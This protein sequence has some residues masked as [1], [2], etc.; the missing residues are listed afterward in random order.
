MIVVWLGLVMDFSLTKFSGTVN[1]PQ[2]DHSFDIFFKNS[3]SDTQG[4]SVVQLG[5]RTWEQ[6][7]IVFC[8]LRG[9]LK[10]WVE[11]KQSEEYFNQIKFCAIKFC[12]P[13][14]FSNR[15][16]SKLSPKNFAIQRFEKFRVDLNPRMSLKHLKMGNCHL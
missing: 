6:I 12:E 2:V 4:S 15:W 5:N 1:Y 16:L 3:T 13:K 9:A 11:N 7:V 14:N 10:G 8:P